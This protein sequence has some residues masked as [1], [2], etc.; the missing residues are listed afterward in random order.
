MFR[1]CRNNNALRWL[2]D[3]FIQHLWNKVKTT[4][5]TAAVWLIKALTFLLGIKA[6]AIVRCFIV[7]PSRGLMTKCILSLRAHMQSYAIFLYLQKKTTKGAYN[8]AFWPL[9]Q[10]HSRKYSFIIVRKAPKAVIKSDRI[11]ITFQSSLTDVFIL[12]SSA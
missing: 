9:G 1:L 8:R 11:N 10:K 12:I 2:K 3:R 5:V 6:M 4:T 7:Y